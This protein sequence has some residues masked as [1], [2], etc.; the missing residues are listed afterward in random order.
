M[1]TD[2]TRRMPLSAWLTLGLAL[3]C[4]HCD[5]VQVGSTLPAPGDASRGAD[6]ST[7]VRSVGNPGAVT[8]LEQLSLE[9]VNRARLFPTGEASR[10]G[11]DLNEGIGFFGQISGT[12]KQAVA[13]N[14]RLRAAAEGHS[15]DMLA[16]DYFGHYSPEG[17]YFTDRIRFA[18]YSYA[19]A[20][21]NLAWRGTTGSL[22]EAQTVETEH[23]DL[24]VDSTVEGRGHRKVMMNGEF[25]EVGIRIVRGDF[26]SKGKT[27]DALMQAQEYGLAP[28]S[29]TFVL[30]VVYHD[31]NV[32][33][34][35]DFGEGV[36]G[37]TITLGDATTTTNAG[38]GYSFAVS[39]PGAYTVTFANGASQTLNIDAGDSNVKVDLINNNKVVVNLGLGE[40][41]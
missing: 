28:G 30:G 19:T 4:A 15:R 32:N 10:Y 23:E 37:A 14:D 9:R 17:A 7:P 25:R 12:T 20:S 13:M 27:F 5:T 8:A 31:A 26:S 34:Q 33:G 1:R 38:G 39:Q 11:I 16:R 3:M 6:G 2:T 24:F 35:Y 29:P 36:A 41:D 22:E 21:E 40:L 18:G